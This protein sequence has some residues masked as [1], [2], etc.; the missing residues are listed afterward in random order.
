MERIKH[1]QQ[2]IK[3]LQNYDFDNFCVLLEKFIDEYEDTDSL[4]EDIYDLESPFIEALS[5]SSNYE[6]LLDFFLEKLNEKIDIFSHHI[7]E[8]NIRKAESIL[9]KQN[10]DAF[11]N[12]FENNVLLSNYKGL[13]LKYSEEILSLLKEIVKIKPKPHFY[14]WILTLYNE[15]YNYEAYK[16]RTLLIKKDIPKEASIAWNF[17][18]KIYIKER[19]FGNA[20]LALKTS[21]NI[22][23]ISDD[24][25]DVVL[26]R[27]LDKLEIV[28][29]FSL[30]N[31]YLKNLS[32]K[33]EIYFLGEN[34]VGKTILLQTILLSLKKMEE[35][36]FALFDIDS[37][38]LSQINVSFK[39]IQLNLFGYMGFYPNVFA[40]GVGRLKTHNSEVD[41]TGFATLFDKQN[42]NLTNPVEFLKDIYIREN[43]G[44]GNLS[45]EKVIKMFTDILNTEPSSEISIEEKG[46]GFIFKEHN[47]KVEFKV[48]ADGYRSLLLIL[49]DLLSRLIENQPDVENIKDFRGIVLIDEIDMLLHPKLEYSI[50]R[51][52]REKLPNIQ[53]F[54]TTHSPVLVMGASED[55]VFYKL[56]KEGGE[57]KISEP[58]EGKDIVHLMANGLIT[59]PL[60]D[61][62][63]ARMNSLKD[64]TIM[65]TSSNFWTG[66][67]NEKIKQRVETE[68]SKG[69]VYFSKEEIEKF[70]EW[71]IDEIKDETEV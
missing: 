41:E 44:I 1:K 18:A 9:K 29:Y 8:K 67:I 58:W 17:I 57:T 51:K 38:V 19:E 35:K 4:E 7:F 31:I 20:Y 3:A 37:K 53:W 26:P 71:A 64:T 49:A 70:V 54:L 52:L 22:N 6:Y 45:L 13:I 33:K 47:T 66:K 69:K 36:Q 11:L 23:E 30:K 12:Y 43:K 63:N 5:V 32:E 55:A 42:V 50:V 21:N 60:F 34:G 62:P 68:K 46:T 28:E 65:D 59:S 10:I 48:L 24:I 25:H 56:Y 15:T 27:P 16:Q 61:M 2:I 14:N 40:Y 39:N